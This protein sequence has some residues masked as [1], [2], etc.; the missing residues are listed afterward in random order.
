MNVHQGK[1]QKKLKQSNDLQR[2]NDKKI[3]PKKG[4]LLDFLDTIL[5]PLPDIQ[6]GN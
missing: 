3:P 6:I 1:G 5:T 2:M 4:G